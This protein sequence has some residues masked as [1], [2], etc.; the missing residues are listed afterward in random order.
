MLV[1]IRFMFRWSWRLLLAAVLFFNCR[2]H[3]PSPLAQNTNQVPAALRQQLNANAKVLTSDTPRQMQRLFPEGFYFCHVLHGLT[4]VEAAQ[5]DPSLTE[6]AIEN[7]KL[8]YESLDSQEC[9]DTFPSDLPPDHGAFYSAWK[10][11]LLAGIVML[12]MQE[13][14]SKKESVTEPETDLAELQRL[15]DDW[16]RLFQE[17]PSPFFESYHGAIWPCDTLPAIHAMKTCDRI[18]NQNKYQVT[19]DQ[20]LKDVKQTLDSET[21]LIPH[22]NLADGKQTG[23]GRAT[24]QMIILR[25]MPDIDETF[26]R[27]QYELF[28]DRFL[29]TF[30]G[31]PCLYEYADGQGSSAGDIDTGPLIF[32]RSI[33]ATVFMIGVAQLYDDQPV[34]DAIAV[35]GE[36]VGLPWTW[37]DEKRYV[38]GVLPIGDIMV[39]YSQNAK[40]WSDGQ[41][42][43][44]QERSSIA[45]GWRWKVHLYSSP[46]FL[47]AIGLWI[48]RRKN[49]NKT[50]TE[51]DT[52]LR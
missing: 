11:H 4:W 44:P 16:Q 37:A 8:A 35:A 33:S 41:G 39:T 52:S 1:F 34:A 5:R 40:R 18:T 46:L 50:T 32:G 25:M 30:G 19:I 29:T 23:Q 28:R 43:S 17:V 36:A 6:E 9:R 22:S 24:S 31:I 48:R 47:V 7:A 15:C 38:G 45:S 10:V 27:Q 21:G 20:W 14:S 13:G 26:A 2:L 12:Q 49:H 3:W 42:H 51:H